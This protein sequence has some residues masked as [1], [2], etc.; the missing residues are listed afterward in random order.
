MY[1]PEDIQRALR[2]AARRKGQPQAAL[3]RQALE[4]YLERVDRPRLRS[5]G[6]GEDPD[7]AARDTESWLES[8]WGG[9]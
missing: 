7:L 3:I 5:V 4:E 1:I 9:R 6:V 8:E 2:Q